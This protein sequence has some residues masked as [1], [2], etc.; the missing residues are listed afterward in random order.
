MQ[1][2]EGCDSVIC[3]NLAEY[4]YPITTYSDT[5]CQGEVYKD[6]NFQN[7]TQSGNY[8]DTLQSIYNC[9]S[10]II[11][12][13]YVA[14]H[15]TLLLFDTI[16]QGMIYDKNGFV[17]S[18]AGIY[19]QNL[20]NIYGC[21]SVIVLNLTVS[22]VGI[23]EIANNNFRIFPNPTNEQLTIEN[24]ELSIE[25]IT[26]YD[27]VGKTHSFDLRKN[28]NKI[29][30]NMGHLQSGTYL[31]QMRTEKGNITKKIIKY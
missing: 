15:D 31:L 13:L 29:I 28:E 14:S 16:S 6:V 5:I 1:S 7:I 23:S 11:L 22:T 9:D 24:G 25:K 20:Q 17:E 3:L 21:D 10:I 26:I 18:E 4:P 12:S 8:Y 30:I 27:I 19:I 2:I